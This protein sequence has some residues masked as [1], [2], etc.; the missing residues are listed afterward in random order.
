V[1][2]LLFNERGVISLA[3]RSVHASARGGPAQWHLQS[4][5]RRER[6]GSC[7]DGAVQRDERFQNLTSMA[8]TS[9]GTSEVLVGGTQLQMYTV[10]LERGTIGSEVSSCSRCRTLELMVAPLVDLVG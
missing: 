8:F 6:R 2:Q 5:V 4:V 3:A 9:R 10:N 7:A 1:R